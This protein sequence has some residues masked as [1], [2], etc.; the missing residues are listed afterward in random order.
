[1]QA[2]ESTLAS[3]SLALLALDD[4]AAPVRARMSVTGQAK[5]A[6]ASLAEGVTN[7]RELEAFSSSRP[8]NEC[9]FAVTLAGAASVPAFLY[10]QSK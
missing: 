9:L 2:P 1:M 3:L 7:S 5:E 6:M 8:L 4:I 10:W